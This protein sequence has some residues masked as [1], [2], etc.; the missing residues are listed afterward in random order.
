MESLWKKKIDFALVFTVKMQPKWGTLWMEIVRELHIKD[1]G[2]FGCL[3]K[4]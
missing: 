4:A 3:P 1:W 2:G